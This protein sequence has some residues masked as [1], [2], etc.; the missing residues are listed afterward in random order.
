MTSLVS[1]FRGY[2]AMNHRPNFGNE[3]QADSRV[4]RGELL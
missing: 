4:L 1:G 3:L 2:K